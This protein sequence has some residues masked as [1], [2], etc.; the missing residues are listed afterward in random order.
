MKYILQGWI[1]HSNIRRHYDVDGPYFRLGYSGYNNKRFYYVTK[2][3]G[4][5]AESK[6]KKDGKFSLLVEKMLR[7]SIELEGIEYRLVPELVCREYYNFYLE[8]I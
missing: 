3:K 1:W 6:K 7:N 4:F 8:M 5:I 2:V